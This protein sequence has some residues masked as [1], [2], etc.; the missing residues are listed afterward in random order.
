MVRGRVPFF[1]PA[2]SPG[3]ERCGERKSGDRLPQRSNAQWPRRLV[4]ASVALVGTQ[5]RG[6][7]D[8]GIAEEHYAELGQCRGG[9]VD[10]RGGRRGA[11]PAT[12]PAQRALARAASPGAPPRVARSRW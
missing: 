4:G 6:G 9:L 7:A 11:A 3:T 1:P 10:E 5:R 2:S 12:R 8:E